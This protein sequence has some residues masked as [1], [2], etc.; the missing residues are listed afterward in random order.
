VGFD[1]DNRA[2]AFSSLCEKA[3][4]LVRKAGRGAGG[5][6]ASSASQTAT[7]AASLPRR[8]LS[9]DRPHTGDEPGEALFSPFTRL[10]TGFGSM[11][12]FANFFPVGKELDMR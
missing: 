3:I 1:A 11:G 7:E 2:S 8:F 9:T 6:P 4:R 5:Q 10:A 12:L